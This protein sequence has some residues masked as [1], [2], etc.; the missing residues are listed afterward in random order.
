MATP[1][2]QVLQAA[3]HET[4]KDMSLAHCPHLSSDDT[5]ATPHLITRDKL[6]T[7][8]RPVTQAAPSDPNFLHQWEL[9][10]AARKA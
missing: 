3:L 5:R 1:E 6:F 7:D 9:D 10:M 8:G 4:C 2:G